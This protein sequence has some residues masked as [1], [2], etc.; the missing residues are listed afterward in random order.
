M[1][2]ANGSVQITVSFS[3]SEFS[4]CHM[5]LQLVVSQFNAKPLVCTFTGTSAP[6]LAKYVVNITPSIYYCSRVLFV[7]F[8]SDIMHISFSKLSMWTIKLTSFK[9]LKIICQDTII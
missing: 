6:G 2:P 9:L 1:V 8:N 3:P 4:T 7:I 5:K